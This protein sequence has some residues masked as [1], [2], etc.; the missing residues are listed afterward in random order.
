MRG[1]SAD[2]MKNLLRQALDPAYYNIHTDF[3]S[4][5]E[6]MWK[7]V[8]VYHCIDQLRQAIQ[9]HSDLTPAPLFKVDGLEKD[10]Y[11]GHSVAHT[12]RDFEA[13]KRW[14]DERNKKRKS[15]SW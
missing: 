3:T 14:R 5:L 11:L 2:E 13:V 1:V 8:H 7:Q 4:E 6:P 10:Y 9:C 15:W 12:C